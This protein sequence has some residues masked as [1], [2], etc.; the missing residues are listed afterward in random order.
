MVTVMMAIGAGL[1]AIPG[2]LFT[3]PPFIAAISEKIAN[4]FD[5]SFKDTFKDLVGNTKTF[6]M[7]MAGI[8]GM[9]GP[10][11]IEESINW[12][13]IFGAAVGGLV[14]IVAV[15]IYCDKL[16]SCL[17]KI[18]QQRNGDMAGI[19]PNEV[20]KAMVGK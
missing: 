19:D 16:I 9:T 12:I 8:G 7:M 1:G 18:Y 15:K 5:M 14:G 4:V 2:T 20:L 17:E 11:V 10:I 13:P 3:M 6:A